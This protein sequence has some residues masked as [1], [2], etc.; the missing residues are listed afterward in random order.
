[1]TYFFNDKD[2][3]EAMLKTCLLFDNKKIQNKRDSF[4]LKSL[5]ALILSEKMKSKDDITKCFKQ[6]NSSLV[7]IPEK[8]DAI[9]AELVKQ[10]FIEIDGKGGIKPKAKV[11]KE[12]DEY[13][14]KIKEK[15]EL[16]HKHIFSLVETSY[17]HK[18]SNP[19]QVKS[20]IQACLNYYYEVNSLSIFDLDNKK[21]VKDLSRLEGLASLNLNESSHELRDQIIY[22]IGSVI[23]NPSEDQKFVLEAIA[24]MSI[25]S[26]VMGMDPL[27]ASFKATTFKNKEFVLDTDVVLYALTEH[28][29]FSKQYQAMIRQLLTCGCNLYI[30]NEVL[31]EIFDHAEAAIKRYSFVS[32]IINDYSDWVKDEFKNIFIEDY[33]FLLQA[34]GQDYIKWQNHIDNY[35]SKEIGLNLITDVIRG[36]FG[37]KI[38]L[39]ELPN[40]AQ[41]NEKERKQLEN[42]NCNKTQKTEKAAFRD[43]D[44]NHRIAKT[45]AFLY[46]SIRSLNALKDDQKQGVSQTNI[47]GKKYYFLT[48]STRVHYCAKDLGFA[49]NIICKPAILMSFLAETGILNPKNFSYT[50]LFDNPFLLFTAK[51][52]WDDVN[53]LMRGGVDVKGKQIVR[54]RYDLEK[55]TDQILTT[56]ADE[57]EKAY[58]RVKAKGYAFNDNIEVV[59]QKSKEQEATIEAKNELIAKLQTELEK[60]NKQLG[61]ERYQNRINKKG[62]KKR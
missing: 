43:D 46:L 50:S 32:N 52:V 1:M 49:D 13:A 3:E 42:E 31:N 7:L 36:K 39:G 47:L 22:A 19:N 34:K 57:Y 11:S 6:I 27:M 16:L 62:S 59:M 18:I 37:D 54:M 17:S 21:N 12:T 35:Y 33:Y 61:K 53:K 45:D 30:P 41:V 5:L 28:A 40:G 24:K 23:D 48:S 60:K 29:R 20:N 4:L 14:D 10:E 44:K 51:S 56:D 38:K 58:E 55:E 8:V 2:L 15:T 25:S 26:Q 9:L